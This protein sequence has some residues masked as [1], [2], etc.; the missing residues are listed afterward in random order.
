MTTLVNRPL[1]SLDNRIYA[2][3]LEE[4]GAAKPDL[5]SLLRAAVEE[6]GIAVEDAALL[7]S[8]AE[9][10]WALGIVERVFYRHGRMA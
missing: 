8:P 10:E 5:E 4:V 1:H 7:V 3:I 6:P 9:A 2:E